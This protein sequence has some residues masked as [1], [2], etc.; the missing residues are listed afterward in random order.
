MRLP[1]DLKRFI[2]DNYAPEDRAAACSLLADARIETGAMADD[3]MLRC[4]AFAGR[5]SL[6][7]LQRQV[8]AL[9]VDWR[10]VIVAGEY[11]YRDGE[12]VQVRDFERPMA[13]YLKSPCRLASRR[14]RS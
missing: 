3:R 14:S 12:P 11:E 4:A 7:K 8:S 9:A 1:V 6:D 13:A 5:G 10:D 2:D